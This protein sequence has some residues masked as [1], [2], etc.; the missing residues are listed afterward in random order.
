[1]TSIG[2][3]EGT[4][5]PTYHSDWALD[6]GMLRDRALF[7]FTIVEQAHDQPYTVLSL[8]EILADRE[9]TSAYLE[10]EQAGRA[11]EAHKRITALV[12]DAVNAPDQLVFRLEDQF[13][14]TREY[15][16]VDRRGMYHVRVAARRLG[17]DTGRDVLYRAG[18]QLRQVLEHM[19]D[20]TAGPA[21][22]PIARQPRRPAPWL[23]AEN[24]MLTAA[25]SRSVLALQPGM[26]LAARH[27]KGVP[28][29]GGS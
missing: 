16:V 21:D 24:V 19:K 4:D 22:S 26:R 28:C 18:Q 7:R 12:V 25:P 20:V 10:M 9:A 11:E 29:L 2:A 3:S 17:A 8:V 6:W 5:Q 14:Q 15:P 23:V 27:S 1:M 13:E